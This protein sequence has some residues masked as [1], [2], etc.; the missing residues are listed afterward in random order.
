MI[1]LGITVTKESHGEKDVRAELR[2]VMVESNLW[3][4][5]RITVAGLS[6]ALVA[7]TSLLV[8]VAIDGIDYIK[9]G[10]SINVS[11]IT[12]LPD[13][14]VIAYAFT[15]E[16]ARIGSVNFV[17]RNT[18]PVDAVFVGPTYDFRYDG[19]IVPIDENAGSV[20]VLL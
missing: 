20:T 7:D 15:T 10:M 9:A 18:S 3:R 1:P 4:Y 14:V 8:T 12:L 16:S 5:G 13:G 17:L 19:C 2:R 6:A 11:P